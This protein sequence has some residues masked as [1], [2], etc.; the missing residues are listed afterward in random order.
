MSFIEDVLAWKNSQ[1]LTRT[2]ERIS[3]I[4]I[5]SPKACSRNHNRE[6]STKQRVILLVLIVVNASI[7]H[8]FYRRVFINIKRIVIFYFA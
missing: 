4:F 1:N 6:K 2:G 3:G 8:E 7:S 5:P